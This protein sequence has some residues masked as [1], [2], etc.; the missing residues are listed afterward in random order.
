LKEDVHLREWIA[1]LWD[2]KA[3]LEFDPQRRRQIVLVTFKIGSDC[4][5]SSGWPLSDDSEA[6]EPRRKIA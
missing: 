4:L 3:A 6:L 1:N 2:Q 5:L